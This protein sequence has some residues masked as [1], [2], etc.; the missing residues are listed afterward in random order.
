MLIPISLLHRQH[1][2]S[3]P[4]GMMRRKAAQLHLACRARA[5]PCHGPEGAAGCLCPAVRAGHGGHGGHHA[6][7]LCLV[8]AHPR[9]FA[10]G[11]LLGWCVC[12]NESP[13]AG[14]FSSLWVSSFVLV[15][16]YS[17]APVH[18]LLPGSAAPAW[19]RRVAPKP[20][21]IRA[22]SAPPV[23]HIPVHVVFFPCSH[24]CSLLLCP[25]VPSFALTPEI[26]LAPLGLHMWQTPLGHCPGA[27]QCP[28]GAQPCGGTPTRR[29]TSVSWGFSL[30]LPSL[31]IQP[32]GPSTSL[33]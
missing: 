28:A 12:V 4:V 14:S 8:P 27:S 7:L 15:P 11:A 3:S 30:C 9:G 29:I 20:C 10:P 17:G 32:H 6:G 33:S 25:P 13:A 1:T 22:A 31:G 2:S 23:P 18:T 21:L 24:C 16:N 5:R 26:P 19:Q